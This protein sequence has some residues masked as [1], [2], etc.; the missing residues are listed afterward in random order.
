MAK[1]I[2]DILDENFFQKTGYQYRLSMLLTE[3]TCTYLLFD[4]AQ[5]LAYRSYALEGQNRDL[6][7]LKDE[8]ETLLFQDKMLN[9]SFQSVEIRLQSNNFTF[10]PEALFDESQT[11]AYLANVTPSPA[12]EAVKKDNIENQSLVNLY[13]L[14]LDLQRFLQKKFPTYQINHAITPLI[15]TYAAHTECIEGKK[16]YLNFHQNQLQILFFEESKFVFANNFYTTP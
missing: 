6:F 14:K 4:D 10:V 11:Y 9:L 5:W 1:I 13:V 3:S 12:N 15:N 7:S 2:Y 8:L 16:I